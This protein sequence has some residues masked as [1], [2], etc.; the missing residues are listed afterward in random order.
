MGTSA[1]KIQ[2]DAPPLPPPG[3]INLPPPQAPSKDASAAPPAPDASAGASS[4]ASDPSSIPTSEPP[5]SSIPNP[6]PYEHA[7]MPSKRLTS[8]NTHDGFKVDIQKQLSPYMVAIHSFWLGTS[9]PDGRNKTYSFITQVADEQGLFMSNVDPATKAVN[10]QIHRALLGG[11]AMGKLQCAVSPEGQGDQLL[12]E[13]D[14]GG[15]TWTGNLK[16]GSMGGGC[17][18]GMN[19]YQSITQRLAM[20]GEGMYIAAN[21]N[22]LSS[23]T[24]KYE[25]DAP[26]GI[27]DEESSDT[28]TNTVADAGASKPS[29]WFLAQLHPTQGMLNFHYKRVVTP[30]RVSLGAELSMSP[31][32]ESQISFGAEFNLTRSKINMGVDGNGKIQTVLET[33]LGMSPGSPTLNFSADVDFAN[34]AMKFGYGLN[35]A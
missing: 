10:G 31:T 35:I 5:T 26:S 1:S 13:V 12:G 17:I 3:Q 20:G 25:C 18:F 14:F 28:I 6:G 30:N 32:L 9:L 24:V 29:S 4:S 23:Y 16:Y 22:L 11:L 33:K 2:C 34:D 7:I 8:I 19:Y 15:M 21:G 27:D